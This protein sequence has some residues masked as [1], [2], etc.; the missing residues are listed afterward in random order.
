MGSFIHLQSVTYRLTIHF[1]LS[2]LLC[3]ILE[4]SLSVLSI[5]S[6]SFLN[7]NFI[8]PYFISYS[9][10]ISNKGRNGFKINI[11]RFSGGIRHYLFC[12][13][14]NFTVR[15]RILS[16]YFQEAKRFGVKRHH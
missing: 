3:I 9:S 8:S 7:L 11:E 2:T 10:N 16:L 13:K 14:M 6:F 1:L 5:F 15:G 4:N 12:D